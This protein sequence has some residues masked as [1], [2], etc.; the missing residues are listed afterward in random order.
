VH[1]DDRPG[2]RGER[3]VQAPRV[4]GERARVDDDPS[5]PSAGSVDRIDELALVVGLERLD[6]QANG[7]AAA[8]VAAT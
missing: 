3:V 6:L 7:D 2:E 1:L 4:V 8:A 5:R